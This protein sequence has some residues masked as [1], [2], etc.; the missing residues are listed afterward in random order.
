[1]GP[2]WILL[3][4]SILYFIGIKCDDGPGELSHLLQQAN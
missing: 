4:F 2:S 3:T 1:M